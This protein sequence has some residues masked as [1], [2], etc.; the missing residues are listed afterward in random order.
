MKLLALSALSILLLWWFLWG[1]SVRKRILQPPF[2]MMLV[3][4]GWFLPQAF[5]LLGHD[6]IPRGAYEKTLFYAALC[7]VMFVYGYL[8]NRK[9]ATLFNFEIN[10]GRVLSCASMYILIGSLFYILSLSALTSFDGTATGQLSG[11]GTIYIFF[12]KLLFLGLSIQLL[13]F[14]DRPSII[15][16]L[17]ILIGLCMYFHRILILGR[18]AAL[19]ELGVMVLFSLYFRRGWLPTR[20]MM[21]IVFVLVSILIANISQYRSFAQGHGSTATISEIDFAENFL[22]IWGGQAAFYEVENAMMNVAAVDETMDLDYG[23]SHWNWLVFRYFPAQIFGMNSKIGLMIGTVNLEAFSQGALRDSF[24]VF[25]FESP[26]IG[27]TSTGL[28]DSF[29]SFWYFGSAIFFAI[30]VILSRWYRAAEKGCFAS[31]VITIMI[32]VPALHTVTH[33]S[34]WLLV[35]LPQ[36]FIFLTPVLLFGKNKKHR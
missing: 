10:E 13:L 21:V 35:F 34:S 15:R 31:Q 29:K 32:I 26:S 8:S 28:S 14:L 18:R 12:S 2:L 7:Y 19:L 16:F 20:K 33:T 5:G 30:G 25:G 11:V 17:P 6:S 36:L 27:L 22:S 1:I 24:D 3:I 9:S 4:V 23:A